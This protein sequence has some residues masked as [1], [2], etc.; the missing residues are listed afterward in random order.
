MKKSIK[1][2][3]A[4]L[5]IITLTSCNSSKKTNDKPNNKTEVVEKKDEKRTEKE[6]PKKKTKLTRELPKNIP[7]YPGSYVTD[8]FEEDENSWVWAF[9]SPASAKEVIE[10]FN[11]ELSYLGLHL[12]DSRGLGLFEV[13]TLYS[14]FGLAFIEEEETVD[15]NTP[16]RE[17]AILVNHTEWDES[18]TRDK[19]N[20][21]RIEIILETVD[22]SKFGD[23]DPERDVPKILPIYPGSILIGDTP[24]TIT[25]TGWSWLFHTNAN[26]DEIIEFFEKELS[27]LGIE[28][29]TEKSSVYDEVGFFSIQTKDS[30]IEIMGTATDEEYDHGLGYQYTIIVDLIALNEL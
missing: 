18:L 11:D 25:S 27:N 17:F 15:E 20:D 22:S 10:F 21:P 8:D 2:I 16:N 12:Y 30:I 23:Y 9:Y 13:L 6:K 14:E 24:T 19:E 28:F 5:L 3:L 1:L 7:I 4:I 26:E 29:A